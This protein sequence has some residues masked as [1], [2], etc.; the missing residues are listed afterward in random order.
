MQIRCQGQNA[1]PEPGALEIIAVPLGTA[2]V[3]AV[4]QGIALSLMEI[5][6]VVADQ[7]PHLSEPEVIEPGQ[8]TH[9]R[10]PA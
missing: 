3:D 6:A 7:G 9:G 4:I 1:V 8:L 2:W 5:A 10:T